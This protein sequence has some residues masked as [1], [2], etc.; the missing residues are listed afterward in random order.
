[1][2]C[3]IFKETESRLDDGINY[4]FTRIMEMFGKDIAPCIQI[5]LTFSDRKANLG[6]MAKIIKES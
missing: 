2:I 1:M 3:F 4:I 5:I 6:K